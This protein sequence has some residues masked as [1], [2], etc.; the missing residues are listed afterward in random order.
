MTRLHIDS[1]TY[2][3]HGVGRAEGKVYFVRNAAPGDE[4]ECEV[5]ED[6]RSYAF[7]EVTALIQAGESRRV[8][9]CPFLPRCGGCPWQHVS[10]EAQLAAK[11]RAVADLLRRVARLEDPPLLPIIAAPQELGYR[12][13]LSLRVEGG[14]VGYFA[15]ASHE[16]VPVDECL[17]ASPRLDGALALLQLWL[18]TLVTK[19]KRAEIVAGAD[20]RFVFTAQAEGAFAAADNRASE[21]FAA[22][23]SRVQGLA[24][25]GRGWRHAW[26]D[27]RVRVELGD[28]DALELRAGGF[29]QVNAAANQILVATVVDFA[30]VTAEERVLDLYAGFGN[31]TFPLARRARKVTAVERDS[32]SARAGAAHAE[33]AGLEGVRFIEADVPAVLKAW[34]RD[35]RRADLVVLD[36]PRSGAAEAAGMLLAMHPARIVYVSCNPSTLARDLAIL[37]G[38]YRVVRVQPIDFFPQTYHVETVTELVL[39]GT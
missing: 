16:L 37:A 30:R 12:N 21:R 2:G 13:R 17:L 7:A 27:E 31:L 34:L 24:L 6:H 22:A 10:Y 23:Q 36:P 19:V 18:E 11:E 3:P 35:R 38:R 4:V 9:P 32:E 1:L 14:R 8:P 39:T 25:R 20:G 26:G 15:A 28:G 29:Q 5:R 33:A